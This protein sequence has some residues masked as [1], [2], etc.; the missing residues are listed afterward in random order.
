MIC[1]VFLHPSWLAKGITM[2]TQTLTLAEL[3]EESLEKILQDVADQ[4]VAITVLLPN[5]KEVLIEPKPHLL[6]LPELEGS[7][8]EGWKDAMYARS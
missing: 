7:V 2:T 6:P 3:K 8:P 5:G 4:H 1:L